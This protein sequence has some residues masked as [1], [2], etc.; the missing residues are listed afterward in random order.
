MKDHFNIDRWNINQPIVISDIYTILDRIEGV[1]TVVDVRIT[2]KFGGDYS[3]WRYKIENAL[4]DG[5]VY[6]SLDPSIFEVK[7][8]N[9][10]IKGSVV[11][12]RG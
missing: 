1:Q 5:I 12:M 6:P 7:Y 4:R 9:A 8:Q 3:P 2:N 10:D 11:S